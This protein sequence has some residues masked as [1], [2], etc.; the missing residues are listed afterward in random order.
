MRRQEREMTERNKYNGDQLYVGDRRQE[1]VS[2]PEKNITF[3][4]N[5]PCNPDADARSR[6]VGSLKDFEIHSVLEKEPRSARRT[7]YQVDR[8]GY[9]PKVKIES[10]EQMP[11]WVN[12]RSARSVGTKKSEPDQRSAE[13]L[14]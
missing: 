2:F 4:F 9:L 6:G 7:S 11:D 14:I 1:D 8:N 10:P 13:E 3:C 12:N 5:R